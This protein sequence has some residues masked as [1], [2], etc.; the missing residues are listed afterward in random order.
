MSGFDTESFHNS[1]AFYD[2]NHNRDNGN[3]DSSNNGLSKFENFM[4]RHQPKH[5]PTGRTG[6]NHRQSQQ[7]PQNNYG[8]PKKMQ[9]SKN[10]LNFKV[11]GLVI[12][13]FTE[14][15]LVIISLQ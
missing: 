9:Q 11:V 2:G 8:M 5:A 6:N 4:Q 13:I 15:F 7:S 12:F 10:H 3:G 14:A 1:D